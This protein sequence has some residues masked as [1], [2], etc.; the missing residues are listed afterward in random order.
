MLS[1][2]PSPSSLVS[3]FFLFASL[4]AN[5]IVCKSHCQ[6]ISSI[7]LSANLVDL[8]V[9][10]SHRSQ[11][12]HIASI[13]VNLT[14]RRYHRSHGSQ[15]SSISS[16]ADLIICRSFAVRN[17]RRSVSSLIFLLL[18]LLIIILLLLLIFFAATADFFLLLLF[19]TKPTWFVPKPTKQSRSGLGL[20]GF[21]KKFESD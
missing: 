3:S 5:L 12:S 13:S 4:F 19:E 11:R 18:L 17:C 8:I 7:S 15:I 21:L 20:D 1:L 14:I 10:I 16:F 2:P 6:Q 9:R